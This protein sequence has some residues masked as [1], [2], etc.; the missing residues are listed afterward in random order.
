MRAYYGGDEIREMPV[1][2]VY[3]RNP[4]ACVY[5]GGVADN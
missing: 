5:I 4:Y 2:P 1:P 3:L